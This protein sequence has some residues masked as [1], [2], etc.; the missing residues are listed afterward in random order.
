[1]GQITLTREPDGIW[2]AAQDGTPVATF[3][4]LGNDWWRGCFPNGRRRQVYVPH[5]GEREVA[6]RLLR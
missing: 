4:E 5:G 2:I 3:Y 1:M 6:C